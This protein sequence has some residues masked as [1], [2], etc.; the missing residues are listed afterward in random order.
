MTTFFNLPIRQAGPADSAWVTDFL[1]ERWTTTTIA[2]HEESI[3]AAKL[4]ALIAGNYQGLATYRLLGHDAELI[5]LD[6]TPAN[7]GTGTAIIGELV[8]R[9]RAEGCKRLWLTTTNDKL[10]ALRF[11]LRRDFR[12]IQVRPGAVDAARK[13]KPTIPWVGEHAIPIREEIDL[14][15]VLDAGAV[16]T[17]PALPPWSRVV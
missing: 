13:R 2:V 16:E 8:A 12:L 10:S 15:R 17:F 11:Y 6:A 3:D 7:T 5:T 1:R 14:C 4:P 9:L